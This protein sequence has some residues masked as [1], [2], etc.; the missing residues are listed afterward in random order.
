MIQGQPKKPTYK[1]MLKDYRAGFSVY[2]VVPNPKDNSYMLFEC[3]DIQEMI[4]QKPNAP[5]T[6]QC[7]IK[8][9]TN[10]SNTMAKK[11]HLLL[12]PLD[13]DTR[14]SSGIVRLLKSGTKDFVKR[15]KKR[16]LKYEAEA[17]ELRQR[18]NEAERLFSN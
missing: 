15:L 16:T 4:P 8:P 11:R 13:I 10:I 2:G 6:M 9:C 7:I 3:T 5:A 18:L 17:R 14:D 12:R 1:R